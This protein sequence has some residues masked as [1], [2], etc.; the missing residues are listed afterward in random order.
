[1]ARRSY[2]QRLAVPLAAGEAALVPTR[3]AEIGEERPP[4]VATTATAPQVQ[5]KATPGPLTRSFAAES[6]P[7]VMPGITPLPAPVV[8]PRAEA[9]VAAA[10]TAPSRNAVEQPVLP[11]LVAPETVRPAAV[12]QPVAREAVAPAPAKQEA[13]PPRPVSGF[14]LLQ[15]MTPVGSEPAITAPLFEPPAPPIHETLSEPV[16]PM[17]EK[18]P[19]PAAR[20]NAIPPMMPPPAAFPPIPALPETGDRSGPPQV[21]I[22]TIEVRSSPVPPP[23]PPQLP[24]PARAAAASATRLARAFGSYFGLGQV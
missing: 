2:L 16:P 1:M 6:A 21:H 10:V 8:M 4:A 15:E 13:V 22:G 11:L 9:P 20:A 24:A 7:A 5:R 18:R 3:Q 12:D 17:A 23:P 19:Q 14:T